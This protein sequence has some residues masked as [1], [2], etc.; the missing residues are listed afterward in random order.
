[1]ARDVLA[2]GGTSSCFFILKRHDGEETVWTHPSTVNPTEEWVVEQ[3]TPS[4]L[5]AKTGCISS[6]RIRFRY[7]GLERRTEKFGLVRILQE[8]VE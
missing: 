6:K 2:K 1:M 4:D 7:K 3:I 8:V 5:V